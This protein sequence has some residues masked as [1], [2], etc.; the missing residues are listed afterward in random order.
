MPPVNLPTPAL[1]TQRAAQRLPRVAL[2][3]F[4]AAYVLPGVFGRDPWKSADITAFGYMAGIAQG[5][6]G[7]LAPTVGGLPADAALLPYWLGAA[8][9]KLL[10]PWVDPAL[11]ARIPFALL[12]VLVLVLTWYSC[13]H[14]AR[15]EAAQPLPFAFGGEADPIDYARAIADGALLALIASLG[16]LQLGHETTPELAQLA[17]V[18]LY[19]YA[20]AA[21]PFRGLQPKL[22]VLAALPA[23]AASG[24]PAIAVVLGIVG[25]LICR[26]SSYP[27]A[28]RF[29]AWIAP[30]TLL[31]ALLASALGAWGWRIGAAA[32][33]LP[34]A[35]EVLRLLA[36][37][38]WPAWPL[39]IW[40]V[41]RWR[42]HL[43]AR[44]IAIP[45]GCTAVAVLACIA[46]GGSER[47]LMLGLPPLAVL[48]AFALPTLQRS[49]A[50][51]I[52]WFSVCLFTIAAIVIWVVYVSMQTGV[53]AQPAANIA[54]LSPG[55][56]R[57]FSAFA[58]AL[59]ILGTLAWLWLVKW[60]TGRNRH[61]L[62]K[63][64]VLPASGVALCWLLVMTLLLPPLDH[65]RSYRSL[66]QRIARQVPTDACIA[67]PGV[68]RAQVVALEH[69][70]G[71][72]VD[73]VTTPAAT[74]CEFLLQMETRGSPSAPGPLW[75]L[76]ARE[77]RNTSEDEVA[78]IY[79]RTA[80]A[81]P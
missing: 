73:A 45:L 33:T 57:S 50:A 18:A 71:Y 10:G 30:S 9:I 29:V 8:F 3:L 60:R 4:C 42:G 78:A 76:L 65:A 63:S 23:L 34:G 62:W 80:A 1:V 16:L 24:A 54:R 46:M 49:T 2:L 27:S 68:A 81:R 44:H 19:V 77:R 61:P 79:R 22:A 14:L 40:T 67:A 52:D 32:A 7:W 51:A 26:A 47:A 74:R 75:K 17:S 41:W 38:T 28:R 12:L 66:V 11:A 15:T 64:L 6:T 70:G 53:P 25:A 21:S 37:F 20:L 35:W 5:R 13:Y 72:R 58:L 39:A 36:W 31:S 43:S 69:L 56:T 48:A 55:Y 59:A